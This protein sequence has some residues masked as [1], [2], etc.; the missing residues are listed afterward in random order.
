MNLFK[1]SRP[2]PTVPLSHPKGVDKVGHFGISGTVPTGG[3]LPTFPV[4][5]ASKQFHPNCPEVSY[6]PGTLQNEKQVGQ[7]F[8]SPQRN[9]PYMFPTFLGHDVWN[10]IA[11]RRTLSPM[12]SPR[13]SLACPEIRGLSFDPLIGN[14]KVSPLE[15]AAYELLVVLRVVLV[16]EKRPNFACLKALATHDFAAEGTNDNG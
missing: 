16:M 13:N 5:M 11:T 3:T 6:C 2:E 15:S 10:K 4:S 1:L 8:F 14:Q 7:F 9:M 12:C